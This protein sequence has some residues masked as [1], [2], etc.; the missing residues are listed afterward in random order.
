MAINAPMSPV[1][2]IVLVLVGVGHP[3]PCRPTGRRDRCRRASRLRRVCHRIRSP[4]SARTH[5]PGLVQQQDLDVAWHLK[6]SSCGLAFSDLRIVA[7]DGEDLGL[8][9]FHA[10]DVGVQANPAVG[11]GGAEAGE[12]QELVAPVCD[13]H[14]CLPSAPGRRPPRRSRNRR[15]P[16]RPFSVN[17]PSTRLTSALADLGDNRDWT[18]AS[19]G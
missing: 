13:L 6:A 9:V 4:T 3:R 5:P 17:S 19:R 12:L 10:G 18:A 1:G 15:A 7:G 2:V 16:S 11:G 14:R 8:A